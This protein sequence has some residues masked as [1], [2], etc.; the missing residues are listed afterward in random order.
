VKRDSIPLYIWSTQSIYDDLCRAYS[1]QEEYIERG[2]K[3]QREEY[4]QIS[5]RD[6][7]PGIPMF[8]DKI[9]KG[10]SLTKKSELNPTKINTPHDGGYDMATYFHPTEER[11]IDTETK[12]ESESESETGRCYRVIPDTFNYKH[13]SYGDLITIIRNHKEP[14][15]WF[16]ATELKTAVGGR[17]WGQCYHNKFKIYAKHTPVP[18]STPGLLMEARE[19][20][21]SKNKHNNYFF[22]LNE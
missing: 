4:R 14:G 11:K 17:S 15:T 12:S 16:N 10:R 13:H 21:K 20:K 5:L 3:I 22:R 9:A 18:D 19:M 1:T 2:L 6:I 8:K 7:I